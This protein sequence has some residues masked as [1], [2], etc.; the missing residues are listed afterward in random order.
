MFNDM[1]LNDNVNN[2]RAAALNVIC[3]NVFVQR[4]KFKVKNLKQEN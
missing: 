1:F 3:L 2:M 4:E